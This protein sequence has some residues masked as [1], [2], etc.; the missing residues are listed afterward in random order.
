MARELTREEYLTAV[1]KPKRRFQM[2]ALGTSRTLQLRKPVIAPCYWFERNEVSEEDGRYTRT[3]DLATIGLVVD[4]TTSVLFYLT[5][6]RLDT[7]TFAF[8]LTPVQLGKAVVAMKR[9]KL[10]RLIPAAASYALEN[11]PDQRRAVIESELRRLVR[12]PREENGRKQKLAKG[13][14]SA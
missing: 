6:S 14:R 8:N 3:P 13:H 1:A 9:A 10:T 12:S 5:G 7:C 11:L 4:G 2:L